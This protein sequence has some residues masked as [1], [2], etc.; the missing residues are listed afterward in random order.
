MDGFRLDAI[1][2]ISK[3]EGFPDDPSTDFEKHTSSIPFVIS[4]G[5]MVHPWM[6]ELTRETFTPLR[7]DDRGRDQRN[8]PRGR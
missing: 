5:T 1:N 4:N 3:P 7:R 6:K 2:I 8:Q